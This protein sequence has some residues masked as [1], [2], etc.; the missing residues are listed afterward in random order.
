VVGECTGGCRA[1]RLRAGL[2]LS[3]WDRTAAVVATPRYND[4]Y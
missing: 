1:E 3:P 2:Y 4:F